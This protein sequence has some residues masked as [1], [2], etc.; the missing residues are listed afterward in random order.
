MPNLDV[1]HRMQKILY[2]EF[3]VRRSPARGEFMSVGPVAQRQRRSDQRRLWERRK[4][5]LLVFGEFYQ[6]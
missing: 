1:Q 3:R 5:E 6:F 4:R 2:L